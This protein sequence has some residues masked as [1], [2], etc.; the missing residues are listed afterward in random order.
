MT[1]FTL[2]LSAGRGLTGTAPAAREDLW[3]LADA[4]PRPG[5]PV[6]MDPLSDVSGSI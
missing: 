4:A 6:G 3:A 2:S 1:R 5:G